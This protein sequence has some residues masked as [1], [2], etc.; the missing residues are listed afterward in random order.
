MFAIVL[1]FA[2]LRKLLALV[3]RVP[4]FLEKGL[5]YDDKLRGRT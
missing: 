3:G 4:L 2:Y 5:Y 1:F